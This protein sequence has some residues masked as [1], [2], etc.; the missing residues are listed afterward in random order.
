MI[1]AKVV[2]NIWATRKE[3]SLTGRKLMVVQPSQLDGSPLGNPIVAVD[4]IDAGIGEMVIV[5]TGSSARQAIGQEHSP[6]DASIVAIID[7]LE[8]NRSNGRA[9]TNS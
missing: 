4:T 1:I 5:A 7:I 3:D 2:G 9:S 6:V 8:V